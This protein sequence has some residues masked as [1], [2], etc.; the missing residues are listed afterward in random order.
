MARMEELRTTTST[1]CAHSGTKCDCSVKDDHVPSTPSTSIPPDP[2]ALASQI[3]QLRTEL[4]K[5]AKQLPDSRLPDLGRISAVGSLLVILLALVK[6]YAVARYSLTT[7]TGLVVTAPVQVVLGT[8]SFY[9]YLVMP[10]LAVT[11][12]W[13]G[14]HWLWRE[15]KSSSPAVWPIVLAVVV[16]TALLSPAEFLV[17]GIG[18]VLVCLQVEWVIKAHTEQDAVMRRLRSRRRFLRLLG[19]RQHHFKGPL[20]R[21]HLLGRFRLRR[22]LARWLLSAAGTVAVLLPWAATWQD[23]T[24]PTALSGWRTWL[25]RAFPSADIWQPALVLVG[26][27][28]GADLL[29]TGY[30]RVRPDGSAGQ[31]NQV[32]PSSRWRP[33][34]RRALIEVGQVLEGMRGWTFV[35]LAGVA[36][37]WF[38]VYF[39]ETPWV[40]AQ[41]FVLKNPVEVSLQDKDVQSRALTVERVHAVTGFPL[42][43]DTKTVT[44]LEADT[45]RIVRFP[46]DDVVVEPTC[47]RDQEQLPGKEA[48]WWLLQGKGYQSHNLSCATLEESL[49]PPR[50]LAFAPRSPLLAAAG[51]RCSVSGRSPSGPAPP[52]NRAMTSASLP[53]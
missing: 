22:L 16:V 30:Y 11:V 46:V 32:T 6:A 44:V 25:R 27:V 42:A 37:V 15:R 39:I 40:P 53:R 41:V 3:D 13:I 18:L 52:V 4:D 26:I 24:D 17:T 29:L 2:V 45:R 28:V 10:L 34:T 33:A 21:W 31:G 7:M 9:A 23:P 38:L 8:I 19:L 14:A 35:Y 47:H 5:I 49:I 36:G 20:L 1:D 51:R 48:L 50:G 12:G 43:D